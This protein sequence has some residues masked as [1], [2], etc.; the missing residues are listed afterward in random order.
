M[1]T[2][3]HARWHTLSFPP[4]CPSPVDSL[5]CHRS[6]SC[7]S[8]LGGRK[9]TVRAPVTASLALVM[10]RMHLRARGARFRGSSVRLEC[11][12][13][14]NSASGFRAPYTAA[15]H[16]WSDLNWPDRSSRS[17]RSRSSAAA[18]PRRPRAVLCVWIRG[19]EVTSPAPGRRR[20]GDS[21]Q[22]APASRPHDTARSMWSASR[23]A[24]V[25]TGRSRVG[26]HREP[27]R[28][29][30]APGD[31]VDAP[32]AVSLGRLVDTVPCSH[33]RLRTMG[34]PAPP[35]R[36]PPTDALSTATNARG[37]GLGPATRRAAGTPR[38]ARMD[39]MG[40]LSRR[41]AQ[42][43]PPDRY[44]VP[45]SGVPTLSTRSSPPETAG[46]SWQPQA[47]APADRVAALESEPWPR[48]LDPRAGL[49][50]AA[51]RRDE[52]D[53]CG[54]GGDRSRRP[55]G[56]LR[57]RRPR[58]AHAAAFVSR[59]PRRRDGRAPGCRLRRQRAGR[60]R[61]G[62][63]AA[64]RRARERAAAGA[65]PGRA[66]PLGRARRRRAPSRTRHGAKTTTSSTTASIAR[67]DDS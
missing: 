59:A 61:S 52:R 1:R 21:T 41:S 49:S 19:F 33:L 50:P 8:S 40:P 45:M 34:L 64:S 57:L 2:R 51:T 7:S 31:P 23:T 30:P 15:S 35:R 63:R 27:G 54:A 66:A 42:L 56:A 53:R 36:E 9:I 44:G 3:L 48:R 6:G 16:F 46:R 32:Q 22:S 13:C 10:S 11:Q 28:P 60:R 39:S 5:P 67:R 37:E 65:R 62:C 20:A 29:E 17:W 14:R 43:L 58:C 26:W 38:P 24:H 18:P 55:G 47:A 12:V 4:R 25:I